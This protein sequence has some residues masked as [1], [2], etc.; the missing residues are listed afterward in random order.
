MTKSPAE[1]SMVVPD[2]VSV[3]VA[4]PEMM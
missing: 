1:I 4:R 2:S 3:S